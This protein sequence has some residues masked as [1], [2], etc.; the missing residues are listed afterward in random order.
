[1][2]KKAARNAVKRTNAERAFDIVN[3]VLMVLV[4]LLCF[5]PIYFT[6]IASFSDPTSVVTGKV[7][8]YPKRITLDSYK[9]ILKYASILNGYKNT[10]IYTSCGTLYNLLLLIPAAYALSKKVLKG[11]RLL[12]AYFIFTMYFNGGLI[13][14][15]L[16][17]KKLGMLNTMWVLIIP[18]ALNVYNLIITRTFFESSIPD[19]LCEAAKIDGAG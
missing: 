12:M 7:L 13:P 9:E 2:H 14:Y 16:Q 1:M 10:L 3:T 5:Y 11:R 15:F 4:A 8:L 19:T 6:V 17:L 18:S